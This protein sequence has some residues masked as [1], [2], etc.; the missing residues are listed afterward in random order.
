[1]DVEEIIIIDILIE[2]YFIVLVVEDNVDIWE[3]I[4]SF[5]IDI[6]EV[7]IVKDGKEGWELV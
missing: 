1:M 3:Y 2:N 6:Y 4:W 7:I 5:F